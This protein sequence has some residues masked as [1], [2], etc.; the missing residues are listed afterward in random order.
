MKKVSV[1]SRKRS[2]KGFTLLELVI[3]IAILFIIVVPL[4]NLV[5]NSFMITNKAGIK[6]KAA[7]IAQRYMEKIKADDVEN[8][9]DIIRNDNNVETWEKYGY[10]S[11]EDGFNIILNA[12]REEGYLIPIHED[13]KDINNY[14]Y[15]FEISKNENKI[16]IY[17]KSTQIDSYSIVPNSDVEV[18]I[19]NN[20][21]DKE[22]K[23]QIG[24]TIDGN[25]KLIDKT[26]DN[27]KDI[28][29]RVDVNRDD[30]A[31]SL[32][33]NAENECD[34]E[35]IFY[36]VKSS[37]LKKDFPLKVIN[38]GGII[39]KYENIVD[40]DG[41]GTKSRLYRITVK[42]EKDGERVVNESYKIFY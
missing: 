33:I 7:H 42:V 17:G 20:K 10:S 21:K 18:N 28:Y 11:S 38:N 22:N 4:S 39:K 26:K 3:S 24:Y 25:K 32:T 9:E 31:N 5:M 36:I 15:K 23:N 2:N 12:K 29:I 40:D 14:D 37:N 35:L 30:L 8:I 41:D 16:N 6:Q 1:T 27:D 19:K 34:G 13:D